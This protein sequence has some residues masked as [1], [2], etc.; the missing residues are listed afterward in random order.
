MPQTEATLE[1]ANTA[2]FRMELEFVTAVYP[3]CIEM[4]RYLARLPASL[5]QV[6]LSDHRM[7]FQGEA[8]LR[9]HLSGSGYR[10]ESTVRRSGRA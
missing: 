5:S 8:L 9:R 3:C 4:R 6:S 10:S 7:S 1:V 2:S